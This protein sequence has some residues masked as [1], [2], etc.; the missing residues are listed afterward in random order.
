[1]R[2]VAGRE[3]HKLSKF[4][5]YSSPPPEGRGQVHPLYSL[6]LHLWKGYNGLWFWFAVKTREIG[7]SI[8]VIVASWLVLSRWSGGHRQLVFIHLCLAIRLPP[9]AVSE[10]PA[11]HAHFKTE[12]AYLFHLRIANLID[13]DSTDVIYKSFQRKIQLLLQ[14]PELKHNTVNGV[15]FACSCEHYLKKNIIDERCCCAWIFVQGVISTCI[16]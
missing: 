12:R 1:M 5:W 10:T 16:A 9:A 11:V 14:D 13:A 7:T 8:S 4:A 3:A 15:S 6:W 2:P